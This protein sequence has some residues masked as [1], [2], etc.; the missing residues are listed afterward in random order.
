[1]RPGGSHPNARVRP[2]MGMSC[3]ALG[4]LRPAIPL[5]EGGSDPAALPLGQPHSQSGFPA[6]VELHPVTWPRVEMRWRTEARP[7]A[8]D[9][10]PQACRARPATPSAADLRT[11][12]RASDAV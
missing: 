10:G 11:D 5:G 8:E 6:E 12:R 9:G 7:R 3:N 1:M 2:S 4:V